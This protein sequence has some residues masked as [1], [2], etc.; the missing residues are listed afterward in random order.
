MPKARFMAG[1]PTNGTL[2]TAGLATESAA[3]AAAAVGLSGTGW[4]C[5]GAFS[6]ESLGRGPEAVP[7]TPLGEAVGTVAAGWRAGSL[8]A[9]SKVVASTTSPATAICKIFII[10][11]TRITGSSNAPASRGLAFS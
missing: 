3:A 10:E 8:Q 7:G 5:A 1:S 9:S 4:V 2:F 6:A 11:R